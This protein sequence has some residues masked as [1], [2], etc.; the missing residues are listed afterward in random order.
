MRVL[1]VDFSPFGPPLTPISLGNL[2][3]VL[4][5]RGH[6]V[7]ILSLGSTSRF[8]PRE[9]ADHLRE[10]RPRLIGFGTYQRNLLQV[11]AVAGMARQELPEC[12]IVLGGPQATFLP[13]AALALL[14]EVDHLARGEGERVIAAIAEAI[15]G[16]TE[17]RPIP[18]TTSRRGGGECVTGPAVEPAEDLDD[19]PSP[20]LSGVLE[21]AASEESILLTSRGCAH[22]CAFCITPIA[23]G[24]RTR[25]QSV[26]RVLEDIA[27]VCRR[28]NGRLWFADPDF[29]YSE[30]R[31]IGILEG[32]LERGLRPRMWIETRADMVGEE[33][34][35]LMRRAGVHTI[36][37]GLESASPRVWPKLAKGV[38]PERIERAVRA[39]REAGLQVELFSQY[40]LPGERLEDALETLR[41]V[42]G[43]GVE[44]RGNS[45]AQQMQLYFGSEIEAD[46]KKHGVKPLRENLPAYLSVGADFETE[47]MTR[48]EI[49]QVRGAWRAESRD[50]GKRVVS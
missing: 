39:A 30:S 48:E 21:P 34:I 6:E 12:S 49:E 16:G 17:D 3:A 15:E 8:S 10:E 22:R 46:S 13:E 19:Y 29:S 24:H 23:S 1:L 2:G 9:L 50:G 27:W 28:G 7:S 25:S 40:A 33:L 36:A 26:E 41:F 5:E 4:E 44:I 20:W 42:K 11:K 35:G 45:N 38:E 37:M 31:V 14:P 43:C 47:W 18:G 32:I